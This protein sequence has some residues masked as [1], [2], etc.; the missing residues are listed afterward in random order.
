MLL[1]RKQN[2]SDAKNRILSTFVFIIEGSSNKLFRA[3]KN[4]VKS[5]HGNKRS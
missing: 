1:L 2:H 5:F 3:F 4:L